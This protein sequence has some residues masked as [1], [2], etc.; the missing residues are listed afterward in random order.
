M[1]FSQIQIQI[2]IYQHILVKI[3]PIEFHENLSGACCAV[4]C[5]H[6]RMDGRTEGR[7]YRQKD[8]LGKANSRFSQLLCEAPHIQFFNVK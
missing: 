8:T 4:P 1:L 5:G 3:Q 6:R 2:R 7:A